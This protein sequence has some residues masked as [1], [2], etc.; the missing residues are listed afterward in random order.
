MEKQ[1]VRIMLTLASS[2]ARN[3]FGFFRKEFEIGGSSPTIRDALETMKTM[4][5]KR[6]LVD[7][8][9]ESGV[10]KGKF[11]I[12]LDGINIECLN[13]LDTKIEDQKNVVVMEILSRIAG[14]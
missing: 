4:D 9:I 6:S 7:V 3:A 11:A 5:G 13:R 12:F 1:C 2:E 8:L 10:M 14:G